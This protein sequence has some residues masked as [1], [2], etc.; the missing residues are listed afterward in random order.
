MGVDIMF[1]ATIKTFL[2]ILIL[3]ISIHAREINIENLVNNAK[4]ID[5]HLF[6]FLHKTDC[7]Y[8]ESMIEFTLKNDTIK[9]FTDKYFVYEH[10]NV[11]EKDR[12][13]YKDF[14]GS[15]R[16]FAKKLGYDFY[17]TTLFFDNKANI[18]HAEVGYRDNDK[19]PNDKRFYTILN[20]IESLSYKKIEYE[21]YEFEIKE[22]L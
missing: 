5:K 14:K 12:V 8:C 18:I 4:K 13:Y 17:P 22:E 16:D 2:I 19:E 3:Q 21:E 10:I 11:Y 20:F 9:A 7:G 6:V 1:T 15:G